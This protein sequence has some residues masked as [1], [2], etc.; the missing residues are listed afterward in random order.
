MRYPGGQACEDQRAEWLGT[1]WLGPSPTHQRS[2]AADV[3]RSA[4]TSIVLS[5]ASIAVPR[6]PV[7][8]GFR[9]GQLD[10]VRRVSPSWRDDRWDLQASSDGRE[11]WSVTLEIIRAAAGILCDDS[12]WWP[13]SRPAV[14]NE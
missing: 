14:P 13:A 9:S 12:T 7:F 3:S 11:S 4:L 2:S 1:G 8:W 10:R 5:G 6:S